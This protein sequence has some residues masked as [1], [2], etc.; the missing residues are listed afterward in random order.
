MVSHDLRAPLS[1][2]E[3]ASAL[4]ARREPGSEDVVKGRERI[5][6]AISQVKRLIDEL[7]AFATIENVALRAGDVDLSAL[8]GEDALAELRRQSLERAVEVVVAPQISCTRQSRADADQPS[9]IFSATPG[10]ARRRSRPPAPKFC[11]RSAVAVAF[12]RSGTM[13]LG[14]T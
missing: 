2:I 4:L 8:A 10:N 9:R 5:D 6:R 12:S 11:R 7:L 14:S 3:M 13:A 1:T